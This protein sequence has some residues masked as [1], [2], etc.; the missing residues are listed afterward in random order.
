[1]QTWFAAE[2]DKLKA[3]PE[4]SLSPTTPMKLEPMSAVTPWT[5][6]IPGLQLGT[7][8]PLSLPLSTAM[9]L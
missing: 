2:L 1:M 8:E 5:P 4:G 3:A 9:A 6:N 7:N